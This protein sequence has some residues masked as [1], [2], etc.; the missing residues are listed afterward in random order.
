VRA[1]RANPNGCLMLT[2]DWDCSCCICQFKQLF[3][4][5]RTLP[6]TVQ[7]QAILTMG[8]VEPDSTGLV[9][10][11]NGESD[12]NDPT[13]LSLRQLKS[14]VGQLRES[15]DNSEAMLQNLRSE[16]EGL[17]EEKQQRQDA[18]ESSDN[19]PAKDGA[20]T[21]KATDDSNNNRKALAD[22][23]NEILRLERELID[24]KNGMLQLQRN[25]EELREALQKMKEQRTK[26][27]ASV[28]GT[29]GGATTTAGTTTA[30]ESGD[31]GD[32]TAATFQTEETKQ[33]MR[34]MKKKINKAVRH[35]ESL[36]HKKELLEHELMTS[37]FREDEAVVFLRRVR[38]FYYMIYRNT[39]VRGS[40]GYQFNKIAVV[41]ADPNEQPA[42]AAD[43]PAL[44]DLDKLMVESG[45]LEESEVGKDTPDDKRPYKPSR[46]AFQRS[47]NVAALIAKR[48]TA[49][50]ATA[51]TVAIPA[52]STASS[53]S[54]GGAT[55]RWGT[56]GSPAIA[57]PG[58]TSVPP[59]P[60]GLSSAVKR[61]EPA[62]TV[63]ARQK[64]D[65]SPAGRFIALR[66]KNLEQEIKQQ[67]DQIMSLQKDL[68][69]ART[70]PG[71]GDGSTPDPIVL[72]KQLETK[73][74]DLRMLVAKLR[75]SSVLSWKLHETSQKQQE[76]ILYLEARLG[77]YWK[78]KAPPDHR[79]QGSAGI[80]GNV[81]KTQQ[82]A[83]QVDPQS[84]QS[85]K[86]E[87]DDASAKAKIDEKGSQTKDDAS[88]KVEGE[89]AKKVVS[90]KGDEGASKGDPTAPKIA[91]IKD[92]DASAHQDGVSVD[93]SSIVTRDSLKDNLRE[94]QI[95]Y[96]DQVAYEK[97]LARQKEREE[98]EK[99]KQERREEEEEEPAAQ[100]EK[101]GEET[102]EE[103]DEEHSHANLKPSKIWSKPETSKDEEPDGELDDSSARRR[104]PSTIPKQM[105]FANQ[106]SPQEEWRR[107]KE[108]QQ[109]A[110]KGRNFTRKGS[111]NEDDDDEEE[112]DKSRPAW[113]QKL[114]PNKSDPNKPA[115]MN[116]LA[117]KG[118]NAKKKKEAED[119]RDPGMYSR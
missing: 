43:L 102:G 95:V 107:R 119:E 12:T 8:K 18:S 2:D 103:T 33:E 53:V 113:L 15:R 64:L 17:R 62:K 21:T 112:A 46:A 110:K 40:G 32:P 75:E 70:K 117:G 94:V 111:Q 31:E 26:H 29:A 22:A 90:S 58:M 61:K 9:V 91:D 105:R 73:E 56:A 1:Y 48:N 5:T 114:K 20:P 97:V 81:K 83:K 71:G 55:K 98:K 69:A 80:A 52:P 23:K 67:A 60:G 106:P 84:T 77:N 44:V 34:R 101:G 14:L 104:R 116:K 57:L 36:K 38:S 42:G 65:T 78:E 72:K 50:L 109:N 3:V 93:P 100:E 27:N 96:S 45:L 86:E 85:K 79:S 92:D 16:L 99:K 49:A 88:A 10:D 63:D 68:D 115:W 4:K 13:T 51:T 19:N 89:S 37:R 74:N 28:A 108:E 59:R 87:K 41:P 54:S 82:S 118:P 66:E 35:C 47:T 25:N 24:T 7:T 76:H 6:L 30:T 11:N 39:V